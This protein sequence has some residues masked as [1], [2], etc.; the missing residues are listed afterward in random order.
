MLL[1][2]ETQRERST[3]RFGQY[4]STQSSR[5]KRDRQF[6]HSHKEREA[7]WRKCTNATQRISVGQTIGTVEEPNSIHKHLGSNCL[8][9]HSHEFPTAFEKR[10]L[11]YRESEVDLRFFLS[12]CVS[13]R[14]NGLFVAKGS[15]RAFRAWSGISARANC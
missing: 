2:I 5:K 4:L 13:F 14:Q 15:T 6:F 8:R 12:F 1:E 7:W 10:R 11:E 9:Q 3:S